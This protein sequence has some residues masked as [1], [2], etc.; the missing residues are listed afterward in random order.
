MILN[1]VINK[2]ANPN[3][4]RSFIKRCNSDTNSF[5]FHVQNL[6]IDKPKKI[7]STSIHVCM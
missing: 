3:L 4:N 5:N 7:Q 2:N 1:V 6:G